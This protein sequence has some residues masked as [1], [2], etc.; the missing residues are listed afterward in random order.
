MTE[1]EAI[2]FGYDR[3]GACGCHWVSRLYPDKFPAGIGCD[4]GMCPQHGRVIVTRIITMEEMYREYKIFV[5]IARR[6]MLNG[7]RI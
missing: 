3:K 7:T 4:L 1:L 5:E 6:R 2:K